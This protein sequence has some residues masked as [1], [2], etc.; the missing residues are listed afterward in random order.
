MIYKQVLSSL[1]LVDSTLPLFGVAAHVHRNESK[2][3]R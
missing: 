3:I 1:I 2:K